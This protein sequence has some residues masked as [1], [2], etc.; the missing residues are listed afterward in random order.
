MPEN[1]NPSREDASGV[2]EII[3]DAI[4]SDDDLEGHSLEE[5]EAEQNATLTNIGCC[6]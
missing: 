5:G 4:E 1:K 6:V 3:N 2:E